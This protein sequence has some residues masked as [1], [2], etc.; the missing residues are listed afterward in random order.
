MFMS[1]FNLDASTIL[2]SCCM[3]VAN[4]YVVLNNTLEMKFLHKK[5]QL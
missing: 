2:H 5:C 3:F 1:Y 4:K